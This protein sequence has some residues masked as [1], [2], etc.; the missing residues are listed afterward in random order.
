MPAPPDTTPRA[1]T[2]RTQRTQLRKTAGSLAY[3]QEDIKYLPRSEDTE[4][5]PRQ[6][7]DEIRMRADALVEEY[8]NISR[9]FSQ[10][11]AVL[12]VLLQDPGHVDIL[13]DALSH[14]V[15]VLRSRPGHEAE[16]GYVTVYDQALLELLSDPQ[17]PYTFGA[18][19]LFLEKIMGHETLDTPSGTD[20]MRGSDNI[21]GLN[22][23][24][25]LLD[26]LSTQIAGHE[27]Y[28]RDGFKEDP[29]TDAKMLTPQ[30]QAQ[31]KPRRDVLPRILETYTS[32]KEE[33]MA[34]FNQ[35]N[36]PASNCARRYP[37]VESDS[38]LRK[39]AD[40]AKFLRDTAENTLD[41]LRSRELYETHVMVPEL[42][43]NFK[44]A[45]EKVVALS[46]GRKRRFE[47]DEGTDIQARKSPALEGRPR[48]LAFRDRVSRPEEGLGRGHVQLHEQDRR[49]HSARLP[50]DVHAHPNPP[51]RRSLVRNVGEI[52]KPVEDETE[53]G[54][55][56]RIQKRGIWIDRYRPT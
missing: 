1:R 15:T 29:S 45:R 52:A 10:R 44:M 14:Y 27:P 25:A 39:K 3:H 53:R 37:S 35:C 41:Y 42:E 4:L 51:L 49:V 43:A 31:P 36:D 48:G 5:T 11:T 34:L 17:E 12:S 33:Y 7:R 55:C 40:A 50:R 26:L 23:R 56:E 46:G 6:T 21:Q 19:L 47:V 18:L 28:P 9:G 22:S 24:H 38:Q 32:A 16:T 20:E 30:S 13:Y 2:I 8:Q 54:S